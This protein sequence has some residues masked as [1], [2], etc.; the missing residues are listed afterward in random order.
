ME[1]TP[2]VVPDTAGDPRFAEDAFLCEKSI[3]FYA[4]APLIQQNGAE[5]G[6]ICVLD[7]RP[8]QFTEQQRE[9]LR[10]IAELVMN[11]IEMRNAGASATEEIH[12]SEG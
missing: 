7:T 11:A 1:G 8:R 4:G 12:A 10:T 2:V 6:S 5:I 3:R 9:H